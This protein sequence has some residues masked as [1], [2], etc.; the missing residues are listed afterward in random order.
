MTITRPHSTNAVQPRYW[1]G[2][3]AVGYPRGGARRQVTATTGEVSQ[4]DALSRR[5]DYI[6]HSAP[7]NPGNSGGPLFAMTDG[8][9]IGIN[10]AR[11][12]Q[13]LSFYAVPFQA[14]EGQLAGWRAQLVVTPGD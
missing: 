13:T 6:P 7:L 3:V 5:Y 9:V 10:T 2:V 11:G 1:R 12:T 8:T 4:Q 14:V